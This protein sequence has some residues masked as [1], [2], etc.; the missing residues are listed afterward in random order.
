VTLPAKHEA[1][2]VG[3]A[4]A[5]VSDAILDRKREDQEL[6]RELSMHIPVTKGNSA[7]EGQ[8]SS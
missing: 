7:D 2:S 1:S 6:G 3:E 4:A 5:L 8:G